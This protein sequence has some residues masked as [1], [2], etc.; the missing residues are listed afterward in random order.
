MHGLHTLYYNKSQTLLLLLY[1]CTLDYVCIYSNK[2]W[3]S[4]ESDRL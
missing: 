3:L 4:L 1:N 2:K